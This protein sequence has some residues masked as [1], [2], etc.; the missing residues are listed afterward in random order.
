MKNVLEDLWFLPTFS[1]YRDECLNIYTCSALTTPVTFPSYCDGMHFSIS[2]MTPEYSL[3]DAWE[4]FP[5]LVGD[6]HSMSISG[7]LNFVRTPL[8]R[9]HVLVMTSF[10]DAR[11]FIMSSRQSRVSMIPLSWESSKYSMRGTYTLSRSSCFAAHGRRIPDPLNTA[12]STI[13]SHAFE[14]GFSS[15]VRSSRTFSRMYRAV[16]DVTKMLSNVT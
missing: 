8:A 9:R 4:K 6:E 15:A 12:A 3:R 11:D 5:E 10:T 14:N 1:Q 16:G 2:P 13:C 7:F